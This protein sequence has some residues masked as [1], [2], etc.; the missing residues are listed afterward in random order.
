MAL[1]YDAIIIGGGL[2]RGRYVFSIPIML[3]IY[4]KYDRKL[5]TQLCHCAMESLQMLFHTL[6]GL[7]HGILGDDHGD[8][9]L[10]NIGNAS[11]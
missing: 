7:D 2:R 9:N 4:F 5:L 11:L 10:Q 3:R 1:R 6:L 8:Q